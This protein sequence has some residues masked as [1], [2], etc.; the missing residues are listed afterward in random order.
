MIADRWG[1]KLS[2]LFSGLPYF[3]GYLLIA[4]GHLLPHAIAFKCF[5]FAGCFLAGFGSGCS[6]SCLPVSHK[7]VFDLLPPA[8]F[9][10]LTDY[11]VLP[12]MH[13]L[14]VLYVYAFT[15]FSH[16]VFMCCKYGLGCLLLT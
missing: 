9:Q 4:T 16:L 3:I 1:R 6:G 14:H 12:C 10:S 2:L 8:H 15:T 5:Y 11:V 7:C 13:D